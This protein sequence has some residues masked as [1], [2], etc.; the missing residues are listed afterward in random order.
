MRAPGDKKAATFRITNRTKTLLA[1]A[2]HNLSRSESDLVETALLEY[3][4]AHNL[5]TS[6][7]LKLN[8]DHL[9][10]LKMEGGQPEVVEVL[11]SNGAPL[12][13]VHQELVSRLNAPVT[14]ELVST[15][16]D[17]S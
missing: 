10:L 15:T 4:K 8:G 12:S 3:L 7:V 14:F 16:G 13:A 2:A 1:N 9:V 17:P 5:D 11:H 6:Y